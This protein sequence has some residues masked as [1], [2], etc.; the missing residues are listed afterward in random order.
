MFKHGRSNVNSL[1][2]KMPT[3]GLQHLLNV[4]VAHQEQSASFR[5]RN[6]LCSQGCSCRG[7]LLCSVLPLSCSYRGAQQQ[8][9]VGVHSQSDPVSLGGYY[10]FTLAEVPYMLTGTRSSAKQTFCLHSKGSRNQ[11]KPGFPRLMPITGQ[12]SKRQLVTFLTMLSVV[13]FF[14][15]NQERLLRWRSHFTGEETK[16]RSSDEALA[17]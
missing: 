14:N 2:V 1:I 4:P 13:V 11:E 8:V 5:F 9:T 3:R 6:V 7:L 15:S 16:P 17:G 10:V 12:R